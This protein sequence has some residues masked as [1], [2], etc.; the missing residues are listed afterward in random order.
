MT[1][2]PLPGNITSI[3]QLGVYVNTVTSNLFWPVVLL[4][5]FVVMFSTLTVIYGA[6][7]GFA[8][9]SFPV[10]VIAAIMRTLQWVDDTTLYIAIVGAGA[11]AAVLGLAWWLDGG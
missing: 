6:K 4:G 2:P 5:F 3:G 11:T 7:R 8:G 9:A 10:A 1:A